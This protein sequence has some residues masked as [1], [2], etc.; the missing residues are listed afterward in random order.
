[1]ILEKNL[2]GTFY[3]PSLVIVDTIFLNSLPK[4][5]IKSG[6]SE[7]VKHALIKNK[8][9]FY[10]LEKNYKNIIDLKYTFLRK[11]IIESIKIKSY[12]ISKDEKENLRSKNSRALLNFGH[13]IGHALE[14]KNKYKNNLTHGEAIAL[15]MV[16]ATKISNKLKFLSKK[17]EL[18]IISHLKN[19][20][21]PTNIKK[22]EL[23]KLNKFIIQD[24]KNY[25]NKIN[26]I[27]LKDIG[28]S[29]IAKKISFTKLNNIFLKIN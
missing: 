22:I 17:I 25:N 2:L 21:L 3:Q 24:K 13:T 20:E 19:A 11:A 4:K 9:Y 29:F 5:Q 23:K 7:I 12:I 27:L 15:G 16:C 28:N 18:R 26:F 6:Y 8:K 14:A 1:M 10:W